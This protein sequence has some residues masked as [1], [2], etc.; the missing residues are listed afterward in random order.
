M[1]LLV[2][3]PRLS[4]QLRRHS[5]LILLTTCQVLNTSFK[6]LHW[7]YTADGRYVI[8]A[9]CTKSSNGTSPYISYPTVHLKAKIVKSRYI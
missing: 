4:Y 2:L 9:L 5:I 1:L 7:A 6:I 8:L 3:P